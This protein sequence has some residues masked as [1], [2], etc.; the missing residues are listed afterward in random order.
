MSR[1]RLILSIAA[2][3]VAIGVGDRDF[4]RCSDEANAR[5]CRIQ[6]ERI[7]DLASHIPVSKSRCS[8]TGDR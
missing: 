6:L 5:W 2:F 1:I 8:S 7:T 4:R 3:L